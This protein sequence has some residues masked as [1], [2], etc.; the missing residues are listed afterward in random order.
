MIRVLPGGVLREKRS[1]LVI[2][3]FSMLGI[4]SGKLGLP[5]TAIQIYLAVT[6]STFPFASVSFMSKIFIFSYYYYFSFHLKNNFY[7]SY[8]NLVWTSEFPQLVVIGDLAL[9]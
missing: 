8:L 9:V 4:F 2:V 7:L 6:F 3:S 1:S 5:P